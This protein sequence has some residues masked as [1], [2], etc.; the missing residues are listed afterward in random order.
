MTDDPRPPVR[1]DPDAVLPEEDGTDEGKRTRRWRSNCRWSRGT[2][3]A[4]RSDRRLGGAS[5]RVTPAGLS[6]RHRRLATWPVMWRLAAEAR[7]RIADATSSGS[8]I[9]PRGVALMIPSRKPG[10]STRAR[11]MSVLTVP[12]ATALTRTSRLAPFDRELSCHLF[13]TGFGYAVGATAD[14]AKS[15]IDRGYQHHRAARRD[16]RQRVAG[17]ASRTAQIGCQDAAPGCLGQVG[18]AVEHGV[19]G[20]IRDHHVQAAESRQGVGDEPPHIVIARRVGRQGEH[21]VAGGGEGSARRLAG[22]GFA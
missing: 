16:G 2:P 15:G 1:S 9:R 10:C 17:Q 12:G 3:T 22:L 6:V 8:A 14:H 4:S 11:T 7:N 21:V 5:R 18:H 19:C 13:Q 20:R